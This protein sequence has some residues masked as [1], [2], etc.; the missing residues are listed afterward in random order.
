MGVCYP[1]RVSESPPMKRV[2]VGVAVL[3]AA[4]PALTEALAD[5][6]RDVRLAAAEALAEVGPEAKE[7]VPAMT[8]LL[9]EEQPARVVRALKALRKLRGVNTEAMPAFVEA[10]RHSDAEVR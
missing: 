1:Q 5:P 3:L 9:K 2:A 4:V 6:S 10:T 8:T 7:A